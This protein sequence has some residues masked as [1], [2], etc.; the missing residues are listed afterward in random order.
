MLWGSQTFANII[1]PDFPSSIHFC[2]SCTTKHC[3]VMVKTQITE[4]MTPRGT[5]S[6]RAAFVSKPPAMANAVPMIPAMEESSGNVPPAE[7]TPRYIMLM[8]AP[9]IHPLTGSPRIRPTKNPETRGLSMV[10][11]VPILPKGHGLSAKT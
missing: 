2:A 7:I 4:P 1:S 10:A 9:M 3:A 5:A 6:A 11:Q 8:V